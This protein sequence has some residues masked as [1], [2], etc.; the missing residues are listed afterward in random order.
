MSIKIFAPASIG[1]FSVGY[2]LLGAAVVPVNGQLLGDTVEVSASD[3]YRL[4]VEGKFASQLPSNNSDNIIHHCHMLFEQQ[5]GEQHIETQPV[6]LTL[7]KNLP[8]GSGLGSSSSSIVA[9]FIA[10]NEWYNKPFSQQQLLLMMGQM[11]AQISGSLHY[12]NIAPC[13]LGGLQL[14]IN[15]PSISQPLPWFDDWHIVVANP[16]TNILT[17]DARDVVPNTIKLPHATEYAQNLAGFIQGLH[18]NNKA[19][20]ISHLKDVIAEPYRYQLLP[21][22]MQHKTQVLQLG[23]EAMGISGSGPTVFAIC[24]DRAT[25]DKVHNYLQL[26]Y[27]ENDRAFSYIC[28][29]DKQGAQLIENK[30]GGQ[31]CHS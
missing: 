11:E 25:A 23:A 22:F 18:S 15:D 16:G 1:N 8:V 27:N 24:P 14:M 3:V 26:H 21:N 29:L 28:R 6:S 5:L 13:Y 9:S 17:K 2:D 19:V 12:D 31:A 20:A 4:N 30:A 10:L 7:S